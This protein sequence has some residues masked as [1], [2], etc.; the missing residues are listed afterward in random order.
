MGTEEI[1]IDSSINALQLPLAYD[2]WAALPISG[3]R[4]PARYKHAAEVV[5]D[6]LYVTGGSRNGRYLS[7]IQV[8]DLRTLT[9]SLFKPHLDPNLGQLTDSS[10]LKVLPASSGHSLVK[11]GK[12]LLLVAGNLKENS[13]TVTVRSVDIETHH[14]YVVKTSGKVPMARGGQSVTLVG[15]KLLMFGGESINKRLLNDLHILDLETMIW[16]LVETRQI[17]P[18]PRFDHTAAVHSERYLLIFGGCSHST[19]FNDLYVLDLQTMEWA[20]PQIQGEWVT[21][22]A[23]HAG[24]TIDNNWHIVG[25]GDNKTG[26]LETLVFNMPKLVWSVV[27]RV[28]GRDPLASEGLSLC[29]ASINGE[30]LLIAFGGYNG[31]YS[32]EVFVLKPKPS[33]S[34]RPKIF[35]SPAA[36]AAAASVSAAYALTTTGSKKLGFT[37]QVSNYVEIKTERSPQDVLLDTISEEKKLLKST[38]AE[39]RVENSKLRGVLDEINNTYAELSKELRSVQGQ[40]TA[41]RLRCF[42][43]E[44]EIAELQKRLESL[45]SLEHEL[46]VLQ[47]QKSALEQDMDGARVSQRSGG[48]WQ[49]ISGPNRSPEQY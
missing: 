49:W 5:H 22:R 31:N 21:P 39:L 9:W 36:A 32:N 12:K 33:D 1:D 47:N 10:S 15:S 37:N 30:K 7:D 29:S 18:A 19:C 20:Q 35:K 26:A 3:W 34:S 38:L 45:H 28:Q 27:T 13:V 11:W 40:L 23:G 16:D 17:P 8:F 2:Q 42:K 24:A 44:V 14:C 41:E 46:Q 43:L 6:K 48:V 4:P 25:G